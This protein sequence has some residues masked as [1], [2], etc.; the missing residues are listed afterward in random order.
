MNVG[1]ISLISQSIST[2]IVNLLF[3]LF[4]KNAYGQKKY[5][6]IIYV[7]VYFVST[8][9]MLGINQFRILILNASYSYIVFNLICILLYDAKL[10]DVWLYN[11]L[12]WFL[13]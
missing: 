4:L 1:I 7:G 6:R 9:L 13:Y 11:S 5:K 10:R 12:Y 2:A 8:I 3:F